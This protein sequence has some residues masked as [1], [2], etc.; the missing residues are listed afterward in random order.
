MTMDNSGSNSSVTAHEADL[1]GGAVATCQQEY[2]SFPNARSMYDS[3]SDE[4]ASG[5][6]HRLQRSM[7]WSFDDSVDETNVA[8]AGIISSLWCIVTPLLEPG[9]PGVDDPC[10][11]VQNVLLPAQIED[12]ENSRM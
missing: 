5:Q 4:E 2:L 3:G 1:A 6:G 10:T 12:K 9:M 11:V 8:G 7:A